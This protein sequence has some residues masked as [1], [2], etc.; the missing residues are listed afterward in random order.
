MIRIA[1]GAISRMWFE[2]AQEEVIDVLRTHQ[3]NGL[4]RDESDQ[5]FKFFGPNRLQEPKKPSTMALFFGQF[6]NLVTKLLLGAGVVSFIL[7]EFADGMGIFLI[8][9]LEAVVG[10]IQERRAEDSLANLKKL[11]APEA[12]VIRDGLK[13][14]IAA[15]MLVPGDVIILEAGCLAPA[16]SRLIETSCFEVE[17]SMLTGE[18]APVCKQNVSRTGSVKTGIWE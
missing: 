18:S 8:V 5:R 4:S 9:V 7:G 13:R 16:D 3:E 6:Q 17:E 11:T 15:N 1:H 12:I 14:K 10:A 2:M